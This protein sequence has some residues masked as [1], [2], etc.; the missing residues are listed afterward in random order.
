MFPYE[1]DSDEYWTA[2]D[3]QYRFLLG[4]G[5]AV[6]RAILTIIEHD[7][8]NGTWRMTGGTPTNEVTT[9]RRAARP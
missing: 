4:P 9:H 2:V 5:P 3:N 8:E 7:E 1:L 6:R